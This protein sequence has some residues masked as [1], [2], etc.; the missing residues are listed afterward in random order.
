MPY[1]FYHIYLNY[2]LY[3]ILNNCETSLLFE[4]IKKTLMSDTYIIYVI[5]K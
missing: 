4:S 5:V 2:N 3:I 1:L